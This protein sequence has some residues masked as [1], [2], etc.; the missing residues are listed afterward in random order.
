MYAQTNARYLYCV[1][2][3]SNVATAL[4]RVYIVWAYIARCVDTFNPIMSVQVD[5]NFLVWSL[6]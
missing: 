6:S 1:G 5:F 4:R 2:A 3:G